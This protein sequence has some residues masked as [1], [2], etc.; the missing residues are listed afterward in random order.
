[1][2]NFNEVLQSKMHRALDKHIM[3]GQ[4]YKITADFQYTLNITKQ[5]LEEYSAA[6]ES[7]QLAL[8]KGIQRFGEEP[9]K[10]C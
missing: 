5:K 7:K 1:M 6:L 8:D 4:Q 10:C 2:G 9:P 3:S